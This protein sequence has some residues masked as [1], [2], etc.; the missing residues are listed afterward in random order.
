MATTGL[1]GE[2]LTVNLTI[3]GEKTADVTT[4]FITPHRFRNHET[5]HP[6]RGSTVHL[7][8]SPP[9]LIGSIPSGYRAETCLLLSHVQFSLYPGIH[10]LRGHTEGNVYMAFVADSSGQ[11]VV[12]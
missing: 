7:P 11:I 4:H 10:L 9:R 3:H 6:N 8:R 12:C 1:L 5:R 2:E